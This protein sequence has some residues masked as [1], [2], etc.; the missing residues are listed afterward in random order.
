M[1]AQDLV[2]LSTGLGQ[3]VTGTVQLAFYKAGEEEEEED[4]GGR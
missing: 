4:V 1:H 3:G 2:D